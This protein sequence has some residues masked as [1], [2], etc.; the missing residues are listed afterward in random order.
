MIIE[1]HGPVNTATGEA[2]QLSRRE[3]L[4]TMSNV[5]T[6]K[7]VIARSS[8]TYSRKRTAVVIHLGAPA[9]D[10]EEDHDCHGANAQTPLSRLWSGRAQSDVGLSPVRRSLGPG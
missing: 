8:A 6:I 5:Y 2:T 1:K 3:K 7:D 4:D 9:V 10:A